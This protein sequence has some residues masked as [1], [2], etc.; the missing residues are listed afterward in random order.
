M[1]FHENRLPTDDSHDIS[2]LIFMPYLLFL[3][4]WQN[5]NCRMLQII[6][7]ALWVNAF[8]HFCRKRP[9][10]MMFL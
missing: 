9:S 6:G 2:C 10:I 1:V 4:K 7:G 3:K 8:T 5:L